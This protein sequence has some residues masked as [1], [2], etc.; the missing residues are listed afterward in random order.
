MPVPAHLFPCLRWEAL[1]ITS[2][3][4]IVNRFAFISFTAQMLKRLGIVCHFFLTTT[5]SWPSFVFSRHSVHCDLFVHEWSWYFCKKLITIIYSVMMFLCNLLLLKDL[6]LKIS[7]ITNFVIC[8]LFLIFIVQHLEFKTQKGTKKI[9]LFPV[10]AFRREIPPPNYIR[11]FFQWWW[12]TL[13]LFS[14]LDATSK[15]RMLFGIL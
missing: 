14:F 3:K 13:I 10:R 8:N 7:T 1:C 2:L 6:T 15:C 12:N 4:D 9:I 11:C 5:K